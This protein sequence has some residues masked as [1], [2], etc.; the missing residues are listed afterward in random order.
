VNNSDELTNIR[1]LDVHIGFVHVKQ[2]E[3]STIETL[4][5]ERSKGGCF[6]H[7]QDFIERTAIGMEQLNTL[8]RIG[9]LRFTGKNK[10]ELLWEANFLHKHIRQKAGVELFASRP[11]N[12]TLPV[13]EQTA[14]E[15]AM[16]EIELL[17]FPLCDPFALVNLDFTGFAA[18]RDL[19]RY[20]GTIVEMLGYYVTEKPVR[21]VNGQLMQFG[22]FIDHNGDWLD[23]VHFPDIARQAPLSGKGFYHMK[24][25]VVDD[26]GVFSVEVG[27][28]RK[29]G[30]KAM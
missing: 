12:F 22:T 1:G 4:L 5:E 29:V 10:K 14:L 13:L 23:T 6:L 26:F 8:I 18:S 9:A 20:A 25:K 27:W 15:D 19:S 30:I 11:M 28:M 3:K 16:D 24:G 7:L 2:L 21:T 17:G